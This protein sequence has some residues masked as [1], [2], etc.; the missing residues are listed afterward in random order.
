M[1]YRKKVMKMILKTA[2]FGV[3][4]ILQRNQEFDTMRF[5]DSTEGSSPFGGSEGPIGEKSRDAV[6]V[7]LGRR[8]FDGVSGVLWRSPL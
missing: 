4:N 2:T 7:N 5:T 6:S 1:L 8:F 3:I